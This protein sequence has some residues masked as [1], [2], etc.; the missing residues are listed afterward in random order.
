MKISKSYHIFIYCN[1]SFFDRT[2]F[3][4]SDITYIKKGFVYIYQT[5]TFYVSG[6]VISLIYDQTLY[7]ESMSTIRF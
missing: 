2:K 1:F 4:S 6:D 5:L 3:E 7:D